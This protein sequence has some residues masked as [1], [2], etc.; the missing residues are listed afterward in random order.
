VSAGSA[1]GNVIIW[2][3]ATGKVEKTLKEHK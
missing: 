1:D 3:S 2:N